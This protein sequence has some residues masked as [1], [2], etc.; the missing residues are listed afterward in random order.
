[1]TI[2]KGANVVIDSAMSFD[3]NNE[4]DYNDVKTV[5]TEAAKQAR[6]GD[7]SLIAA[8]LHNAELARQGIMSVINL[9]GE[10][11][12]CTANELAD[13]ISNFMLLETPKKI[14]L[15]RLGHDKLNALIA[16]AIRR[17]AIEE[18]LQPSEGCNCA[19]CSAI[20]AAQDED[21]VFSAE[22]I[23]SMH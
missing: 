11:A 9:F 12:T 15:A 3:R 13:W 7:C 5:F 4:Q 8:L 1:M 20:R 23:E 10:F 6:E 2:F 16:P 17:K 22:D 14:Q 18:D 21:Q 19:S